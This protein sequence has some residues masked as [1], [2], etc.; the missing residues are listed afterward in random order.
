MAEEI[1]RRNLDRAFGP[2]PD[3][4]HPS[5]LSR[6][7][8]AVRQD[9][10]PSPIRRKAEVPTWLLPM[11]AVLLAIA[12]VAVVIGSNLL[13]RNSPV[14]VRPPTPVTTRSVSPQMM[15]PTSGWS[16]GSKGLLRTG[17]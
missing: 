16:N 7:M 4:P 1:L 3:F 9:V 12:I 14:P 17:D 10:A 6:T 2:G 8:A 11:V 13:H 5:L 15:S